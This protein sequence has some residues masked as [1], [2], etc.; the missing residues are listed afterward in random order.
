[1]GGSTKITSG[2]IATYA[3]KVEGSAIPDESRVF[4]IHIEKGINRIPI[5]RVTILDGD[6]S[7]GKFEASSS[8]VFVPGN[9]IS[10]EAGYDTK[11]KVIFE[12][13][14]TGQSLRI[15]DQLGSALIV[16]C[17]DEAIKMIVGRKSL[18]FTK[19][20][21][22]AIL[23]QIIGTYSG[24]SAAVTATTTEWPSQVQYYTTDWDFVMARAEANGF[25]VNVINGKIVIGKPDANSSSVL[26]VKYG[27]NMYAFDA[28]LNSINQLGDVKGETWDFKTQ[29]TINGQASNSIAGPGNLSSKK[30]AEVVGLDEFDLQTGANIASGDL[31]NWSKAQLVKSC[32]SKIRGEVSF[33]GSNVVEPCN[34]ITIGGLGDR[35]NGDHLVGEVVHDLSEGNWITE[36]TVGLSDEWFTAETDVMAPPA[37]GLL[38]GARGLFNG[39][40]KKMYADPDSQYR[41]LVD[42]PL[43]DANGEGIWA[44]MANFYSTA[45]AGAFFMPEVGDEVV[46]GFLNEDPRFPIILGSLYSSSS[47]KPFEGLN[48]DEKNTKKAIVSKTGLFVQFD[49]ENKILTLN[50]PQK[51]TL[52][53]SDQDKEISIKDQNGNSIVMNES[54]ITINSGKDINIT[55]TGSLN[56]KGN[57]GVNIQAS[58][59]DVAIKGMNVKANGD[60]Q[61]SAE[62][63]MSASVQGGTELTLKGAMVMIN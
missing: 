9:K 12:G 35:F 13:I 14:I 1:M 39:T 31:D 15:D 36:V 51:N 56:L 59:G 60:M 57:A 45:G 40:V 46:I 5:A 11:N 34:Y 43:F 48:P 18:T 33:Q 24:L 23:S 50:T 52:I 38:P 61:F 44:R 58:G 22:S 16:V 54:G 55:A 3:I 17:R 30:L 49:D 7:T 6:A 27:D 25:V 26:S 37:A 4:S 20:K 42:I 41:I 29:A 2:G 53:L 21:D 10:I 8:S 63:G 32:F 62:G 28:D 47:I 19:K